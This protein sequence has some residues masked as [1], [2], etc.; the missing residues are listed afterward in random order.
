[1]TIR[2]IASSVEDIVHG[3]LADDLAVDHHRDGLAQRENLARAVGIPHRVGV[4]L[5]LPVDQ[6]DD[7]LDQLDA[8][9]REGHPLVFVDVEA[10]VLHG[11][12]RGRPGLR[13]RRSKWAL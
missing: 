11:C 8:I 10:V 4:D 6:V 1:M 7:P 13:S 2:P 9:I 3:D 5:N 12:R